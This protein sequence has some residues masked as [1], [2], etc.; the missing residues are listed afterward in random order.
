MAPPVTLTAWIDVLDPWSWVVVTRLTRVVEHYGDTVAFEWRAFLRY[1]TKEVRDLEEWRRS[2]TEWLE[3]AS[4][5][6]GLDFSLWSTG[7]PPPT[8]SVPA[9]VAAL[10]A[11]DEDP[12]R[13]PDYLEALFRAHFTDNRT[14][15]DG[16]TLIELAGETGF[17]VD[18]FAMRLRGRYGAYAKRTVEQ[19]NEGARRQV[20][21][22][23]AVVVGG[24]YLVR[25][26]ADEQQYREL[27]DQ[28]LAATPDGAA[29][30]ADNVESIEAAAEPVE[31]VA[32]TPGT[33][34]S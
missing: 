9:L 14:V 34:D 20:T 25:G 15:S 3:P 6:P 2:T 13:A 10:V 16:R 30:V 29:E 22:A 18:A 21:D 24:E 28:M 26:P 27:I 11:L 7:N 17:D 4:A 1:P 5:E 19:H 32:G 31:P 12:D 33:A 23:P 8:H